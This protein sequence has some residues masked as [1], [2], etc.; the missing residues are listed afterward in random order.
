MIFCHFR[1][2]IEGKIQETSLLLSY[3]IK[4]LAIWL[5]L[6]LKKN[7]YRLENLPLRSL[8]TVSVR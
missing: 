3:L 4:I 8:A 2:I 1:T 6:Q 5:S 7:N